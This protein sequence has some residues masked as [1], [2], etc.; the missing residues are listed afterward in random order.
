[1]STDTDFAARLLEQYGVES[2]LPSRD[3]VIELNNI[4][5]VFEAQDYEARHPEIYKHLPGLWRE[6]IGIAVQQCGPRELRILDFGCGTGFEAEQIIRGLPKGTIAQLTCYD[7]SAEML[8]RCHA[9]ISPLFPDTV[10]VSD[11]EQLQVSGE[12][13]NLL[14]TNSLLHH[15]FDPLGTITG[16][17]PLLALDAVWLEGHEPSNRFY[18]NNECV[19]NLEEFLRKRKWRR[20]LHIGNYLNRVKRIFGLTGDPVRQTAKE[21]FRKGLFEQEPPVEVINRL[22]DFH[23]PRSTEEASSGRGFDF[24]VMQQD[25]RSSWEL[26]W[27]KTYGKMTPRYEKYYSK[28]WA[29]SFR[30]LASKFPEDGAWFSSVWRRSSYQ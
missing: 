10:F 28:K 3:L 13:Y 29:Q 4:Y 12:P 7:P 19:R 1:M 17:L 14:A 9:R 6:M 15:L 30:N 18:K 2:Q 24:K 21:A 23:I 20:Y 26:V 8:E 25:L 16:L 27:V 11:C 22:V 5:H